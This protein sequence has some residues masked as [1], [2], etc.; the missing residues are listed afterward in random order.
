MSRTHVIIH[1]VNS[2]AVRARRTREDWC[3]YLEIEN[4]ATWDDIEDALVFEYMTGG[5]YV[6]FVTG[7]VR[8]FAAL[9]PAVRIGLGLDE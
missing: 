9:P 8:G 3:T 6:E 4:D 7:V 1:K 2:D 5:E